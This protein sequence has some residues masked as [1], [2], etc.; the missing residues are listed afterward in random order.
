MRFGFTI[1]MILLISFSGYGQD[2]TEMAKNIVSLYSKTNVHYDIQMS[3]F[4]TGTYDSAVKIAQQPMLLD[5]LFKNPNHRLNDVGIDIVKD[6]CV[7]NYKSLGFFEI[8]TNEVKLMVDHA[9]TSIVWCTAPEIPMTRM[10]FLND[11]TTENHR[12]ELTGK[13]DDW[14]FYEKGTTYMLINTQSKNIYTINVSG[15]DAEV[16]IVSTTRFYNYSSEPMLNDKHQINHYFVGKP[17]E[18]NLKEPFKHY[19]FSTCPSN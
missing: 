12:L 17:S 7:F 5:S 11:L 4:Y 18:S 15:I 6:T 8:G 19:T 3:V 2:S 13:K 9:D 16:F 10:R 1:C 14:Y